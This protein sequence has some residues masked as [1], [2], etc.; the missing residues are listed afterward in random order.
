MVFYIS[1][2]ERSVNFCSEG[3]GLANPKSQILML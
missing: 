2:V 1:I 3:S